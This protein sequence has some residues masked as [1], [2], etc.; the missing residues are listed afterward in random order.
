MK[1]VEVYKFPLIEDLRME[2]A[3]KNMEWFNPNA[4]TTQAVRAVF[5][6]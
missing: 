2:V 4:T 5:I 1:N 3:K 6:Y